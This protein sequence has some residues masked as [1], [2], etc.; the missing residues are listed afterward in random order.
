MNHLKFAHIICKLNIFV[1]ISTISFY[2]EKCIKY[3][4]LN[5]H[6]V[7]GCFNLRYLHNLKECLIVVQTTGIVCSTKIYRG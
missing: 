7:I 3:T 6:C 2:T 1:E 4:T 5:T